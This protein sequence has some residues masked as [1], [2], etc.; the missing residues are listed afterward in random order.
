[1]NTSIVFEET[2]GD[3]NFSP[4]IELEY[5]RLVDNQL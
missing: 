2:R 1:M 3:L 5:L 4:T